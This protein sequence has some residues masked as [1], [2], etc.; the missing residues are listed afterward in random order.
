MAVID[1]EA[2]TEAEYGPHHGG[3]EH[4]ADYHRNGVHVE[5]Y[6]GDDDRADENEYVGPAEMYVLAYRYAGPVQVH[7]LGHIQEGPQ[8]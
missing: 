1:T 4:R 6:G 5:A 7:K 8:E 2:E 3:N